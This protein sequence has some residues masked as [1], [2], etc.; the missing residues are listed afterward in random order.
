[1]AEPTISI[2]TGQKVTTFEMVVQSLSTIT[3]TAT[4]ILPGAVVEINGDPIIWEVPLTLPEF[5]IGPYGVES[6]IHPT[7]LPPSDPNF[8]TWDKNTDL[9]KGRHIV[10]HN[11][12]KTRCQL[13]LHENFYGNGEFTLRPLNGQAGAMKTSKEWRPSALK[14]ELEHIYKGKHIAFTGIVCSII[15]DG[16]NVASILKTKAILKK[17]QVTVVITNKWKTIASF[18]LQLIQG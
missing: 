10:V 9:N 8:C 17:S 14:V 4:V 1:M 18:P 6:F 11:R 3:N 12:T 13:V 5:E 15:R 7:R 16:Q 2:R